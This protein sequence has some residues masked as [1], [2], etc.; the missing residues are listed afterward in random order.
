MSV[1][2]QVRGAR[3]HNLV[4][5]DV[6]LPREQLIVFTGPSGSG[7]SSLA[8]HV[9]HALGERNAVRLLS[10]GLQARLG[11]PPRPAVDLVRHLPPTQAIAADRRPPPAT[12]VARYVQV[13]GLLAALFLRAGTFVDPED[14]A[15]LPTHD[16][17]AA[18]E[19][20]MELAEGTRLTLLAPLPPT[21]DLPRLLE[22]IA[23][24][25]FSRVR[26]NGRLQRIEE[27]EELAASGS[28][29]DLA[30][31]V[32][33]IRVRP[34]SSVRIR[35]AVA[36]AY[37]AGMG[38][39]EATVRPPEGAE[40]NLH[41]SRAPFNPTTGARYHRPDLDA[42]MGRVPTCR[43]CGAAPGVAPADCADCHGTG[44]GAGA[45]SLHLGGRGLGSLLGGS[46]D[47]VAEW[48][49]SV[50]IPAELEP[51]RA[52]LAVELESACRL[53]LG[54]LP[55]WRP[56]DTL[57]LGEWSRL[58][59]ARMA[60]AEPEGMLLVVDEPG[61]GLA[62]D[63]LAAVATE[64]E[65]LRDAGNTVLVVAHREPLVA[66]ADHRVVF[67]PG[68]GEDGGRIVWSG[69]ATQAPAAGALPAPAAPGPAPSRFL[70]L[71]APHGSFH[72]ARHGLT[73][74]MGPSASGR[75]RLLLAHLSP[76]LAAF[77]AGE[78]CPSLQGAEGLQRHLALTR[79]PTVP[80]ARSCVAT[81]GGLWTPLRTLLAGSR[82][83][84][85]RGLS[86]SHFSLSSPGARCAR[87]EGRGT[88]E[89]PGGGGLDAQRSCPRCEGRR[90]GDADEGIRFRGFSAGGLMQATVSELAHR[91]TGHPKL[92]SALAALEAV[93]LGY[94][95]LGRSAASLSGG[96]GQRLRLAGVLGRARALRPGRGRSLEGLALL[97]D[98]PTSGLSRPDAARVLTVLHELTSRGATVVAVVDDPWNA[99]A[100]HQLIELPGS[101]SL[102]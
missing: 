28:P 92:L 38:R 68:A 81:L 89:L 44:L 29:V 3:V 67:G 26:L 46:V 98:R 7:K 40:H 18:T 63:D 79:A 10:P 16:L 57:A 100:A 23:R 12:S 49:T 6:D 78:D 30:L 33:R 58:Q 4:G 86:T 13:H 65:R 72:F 102:G 96:E 17:R 41:F 45:R 25:G 14:G 32:D 56:V 71:Q 42:L 61:L 93:G 22:E 85:V 47:G 51:I 15:R 8:L 83:A 94:L 50:S 21:A 90:F 54:E 62:D 39:M 75:Q 2:I 5:V 82:E 59:L 52:A 20:L 95:P 77:L 64:L 84:R 11:V 88:V 99:G 9:L 74:L 69:P 36:S 70:E 80:H 35:E 31:V 91:V 34:D 43:T 27:L 53:G 24:Q 66:R 37:A 73:M 48:T 19:A 76:A 97:L 87:C 60:G 1:S 55:L 101:G